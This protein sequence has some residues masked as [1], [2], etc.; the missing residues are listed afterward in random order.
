MDGGVANRPVP[1]AVL[2]PDLDGN[3]TAWNP[4][5]ERMHFSAKPFRFATLLERLKLMRRRS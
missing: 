1:M 3:V 4:A 5:A 2:S